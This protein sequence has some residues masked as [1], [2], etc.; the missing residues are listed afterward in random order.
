M[1]KELNPDGKAVVIDHKAISNYMAAAIMPFKVKDSR[2]LDGLMR[3]D[4]ITA[5][6][7]VAD[8]ENR[9]NLITT[10]EARVPSTRF[11]A[12]CRFRRDFLKGWND[13]RNRKVRVP[14]IEWA[15]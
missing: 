9:L 14:K 15:R 13:H 3:D 6:L 10:R 1:V 12:D 7:H 2:E 4:E 5:R 8:T 11:P